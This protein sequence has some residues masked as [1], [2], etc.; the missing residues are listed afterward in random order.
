MRISN[1]GPKPPPALPDALHPPPHSSSNQAELHASLEL[2]ST[3]R[4]VLFAV[5][6]VPISRVVLVPP[7]CAIANLWQRPR[8]NWRHS[9]VIV[10]AGL[11]GAVAYALA[12][13]E[14]Q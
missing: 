7:L 8:I 4:L 5:L 9:C 11:R 3:W 14:P 10:C 2:S 6:A 1:P 13:S 12:M